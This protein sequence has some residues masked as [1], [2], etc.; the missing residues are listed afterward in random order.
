MRR[1]MLDWG[2]PGTALGVR[3]VGR[4]AQRKT[5]MLKL[6]ACKGRG[7]FCVERCNGAICVGR[8]EDPSVGFMIIGSL[9]VSGDANGASDLTRLRKRALWR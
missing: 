8:R 6:H 1:G 5:L 2:M 3:F 4:F 9:D 7:E